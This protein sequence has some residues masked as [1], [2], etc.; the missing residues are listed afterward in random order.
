MINT[1]KKRAVILNSRQGLRPV[2]TDAWIQN[3]LKAVNRA[4]SRGN[5]VLT[6]AGMNSWE[7]ILFL[8]E[9]HNAFQKIY[10]PL[11]KSSDAEPARK[12]YCDQFQLRSALVDWRFVEI[13]NLKKD[14]GSFQKIRDQLIINDADILYP[15]SIRPDGNLERLINSAKADGK[16]VDSGFQTE[17]SDSVYSCKIDLDF[18]K[19]NSDI[20]RQLEDC[21]I[22]WTR[23]SNS[24]WPDETMY[25]YYESILNSTSRY[26]RSGFDTLMRILFEKRLRASSRHLRKNLSAVAFS[27]LQPTHAARLMKWRAR[28]HEMT[29]EP[30]GIAID[31]NFADTIGIRK[32][33]Y[34]NQEMYDFLE[35]EN[36]P[37]FQ[38]VGTKGYWIPEKEYR[39]IGDIDLSLIP[40][41]SITAIVW[42]PAEIDEIKEGFSG[43]VIGLYG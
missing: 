28:Y 8:A 16:V 19:L 1:D 34:G 5:I 24:P 35:D 20:D 36:K 30:Y 39:H 37:Y 27:S 40:H 15:V 2:G 38:S 21:V 11:D 3:S 29:F 25:S 17:Y 33:F 18:D 31:K 32:V 14:Y 10:L 41:D 13:G 43:R 4:I 23:S 26:P 12:Y 22:H 9:K 6:S 7:M 42:R